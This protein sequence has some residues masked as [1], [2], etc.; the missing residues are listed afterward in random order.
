MSKQAESMTAVDA[1][2]ATL[3]RATKPLDISTLHERVQAKVGKRKVARAT[4]VAH[5]LRKPAEF[6]RVDRGTYT[7]KAA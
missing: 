1:M 3:K 2:R 6:K 4:I 7:I 5:L